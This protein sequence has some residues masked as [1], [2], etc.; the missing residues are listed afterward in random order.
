MIQLKRHFFIL[1][2]LAITFS[3]VGPVAAS[4]GN[5]IARIQP[6]LLEISQTA[7]DQIVKVIV[8]RNPGSFELEKRVQQLGG[9][10]TQDLDIINSFAAEMTASAAN[11]IAM[12]AGVRWVSLDAPL[13]A[14]NCIDCVNDS[15]LVN[16]YVQSV[17]AN[18]VWD[19]ATPLQ[20]QGIGVAV[21]DSG[22][23]YSAD[24]YTRMGQ[25]RVV[26]SVSFQD[27]YNQSTFDGYGH[28]THIAGVVGGDGDQSRGQYIGIAPLSNII[29]VKVCDD[30]QSGL[31]TSQSI[32][33]G[34]QWVLEHK[35]QYNI[36]VVNISLNS[37]I[38]ESYNTSP[39]NAAVELLWFNGVV[40]VVSAGNQG[41]TNLFAPANDPFAIVVGAVDEKNTSDIS[42]DKVA[43]FS[44]YGNT[45]DGFAKP[46]LVAPGKNI[47]SLIGNYGMGMSL[48]HPENIVGNGYFTMS[49]T[50]VAAPIVSGAVALLLQDEPNLTP[51]QVKYRL[52]AT[53]NKNWDEYSAEKAGAGILDVQ[54]A[55]HGNTT[56]RAN[57]GVIPHQLL[58]KMALIALWANQNGDQ[59]INWGNVNWSSVNW[60]SV[61]WSSVN[62]S[63][64][65]WSS[66][67]WSSVN[68]SSVN[69]SSVNWS[70]VNWSSV[71]W[72]SVNWSSVNWSSV[73]WSSVSWNS[74]I[75]D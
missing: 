46:D 70:S 1:L 68:W 37:S 22:V 8:Q 25:N 42:N 10:V 2:I 24:L 5:D 61:N 49:G 18:Q 26:A 54:A 59:N 33:N 31:C 50:S 72:S 6:Y 35:D 20:G 36:R 67:N 21:I 66:V 48:E 53:A 13:V 75:W 62:W 71:N 34:L 58:A 7:P 39:I 57:Q 52:M 4:P 9:K 32:V 17:R 40:V 69:W 64:V 51:D 41:E 45:I 29:N 43:G 65:N 44:A 3:F 11:Q 38:P 73:N 55:V 60:S 16:T 47:V 12:D 30:L 56:E 63:S 19:E 28:G 74:D 23:N 27:G 15:S 14:S